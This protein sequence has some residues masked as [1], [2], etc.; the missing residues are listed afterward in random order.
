MKKWIFG[1][2]GKITVKIG[3]KLRPNRLATGSNIA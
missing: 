1:A 2:E 3:R